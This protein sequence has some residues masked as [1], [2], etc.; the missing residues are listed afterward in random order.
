MPTILILILLLA[1]TSYSIEKVC[2]AKEAHRKKIGGYEAGS[3]FT[4]HRN[5][6]S[7]ARG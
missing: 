1:A 4:F 6:V 7:P 3:K 5:G 2:K